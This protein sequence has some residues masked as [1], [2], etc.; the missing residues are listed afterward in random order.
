MHA[1][2]VLGEKGL[3]CLSVAAARR[4]ENVSVIG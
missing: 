1:V 4:G 2:V 3:E